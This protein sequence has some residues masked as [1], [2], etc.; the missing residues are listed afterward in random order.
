MSLEAFSEVKTDLSLPSPN[1]E[2]NKYGQANRNLYKT[3]LDQV[4]TALFSSFVYDEIF[5]H[6]RGD[7]M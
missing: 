3:N 2:R 6:R 1:K 7:L 5:T 4:W